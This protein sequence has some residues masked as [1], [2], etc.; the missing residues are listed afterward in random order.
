MH[1]RRLQCGVAVGEFEVVGVTSNDN[2]YHTLDGFP[3]LSK[4]TLMDVPHD[5]IL[6]TSERHLAEIREEYVHMGGDA[7]RML[8]IGV[9]D[10]AN[11]TF[12]QVAE[13][14]RSRVSIIANNCWGGVTYHMLH[15]KFFSPLINMFELDRDYLS[16]LRD[17]HHRIRQPLE[18]VGSAEND[19]MQ[20][21]YPIFSLGGTR[22]HMNHDADENRAGAVKKWEERL[23]RLNEENLFF[24]MYT[25][26]EAAAEEFDALP[27]ERK[28]CFTSFP[29]DLPSCMYAKPYT[30]YNQPLGK[31]FWETVN[32]MGKGLYPF[33]DVYELLMHGKKR[34]RSV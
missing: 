2:W 5:Y 4:D 28:I 20:L 8:P 14:H 18:Y 24:M 33:Y 3:F 1:V 31:P 29:T 11:L 22:L 34:Y 7:E 23:K 17:F 21:R 27:L 10:V 26:S 32:G 13:L 9:L 25:E 6:V 30:S 15:M 12:S 16:L 19:D